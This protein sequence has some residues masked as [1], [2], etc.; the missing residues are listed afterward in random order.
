MIDKEKIPQIEKDYK[1]GYTYKKLAG[2]YGL[3]Y[4]QVTYLI[5]KEKWQRQ[6][7]LSITHIGNKNA[8]GNCGGPGATKG[9]KNAVTTGE[10]ETLFF[11]VLTEEEQRL[12]QNL[13]IINKKKCVENEYKMLAI[14]EYRV[15]KKIKT[16]QD[17]EKDMNV[18]RIVKRQY[19]SNN[20]NETETVTEAINVITPL[21]KLEDALTRIQDAK[22]KCLD[23]LHRMETDDRRLELDL[24]RLEMEA[25][26]EDSA[27]ATEEIKDDSFIEA[28]NQSAKELTE[29]GA[30]EDEDTN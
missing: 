30:W 29:E 24:V 26:K 14:R 20:S 8:V 2:K 7:N 5:K 27:A 9:N 23:T 16:I 6:S 19:N 12:Y 13:E 10:Y 22:R 11:D 25:A 18:E 21:Q 28:L 17:K 3:T 4:N 1:D 15:L